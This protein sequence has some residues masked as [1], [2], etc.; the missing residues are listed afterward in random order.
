M[1]E[2]E[3][4]G[5]CIYE[6]KKKKDTITLIA[7]KDFGEWTEK[8][9]SCKFMYKLHDMGDGYLFIDGFMDKKFELDYCQAEA[10]LML[11]KL[12]KK[13]FEAKIFKKEKL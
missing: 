6:Y 4:G 8:A 5:H 2:D 12:N 10:L 11:L 7:S 3:S 1:K 13:D 9:T